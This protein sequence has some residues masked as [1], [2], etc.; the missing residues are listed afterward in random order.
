M[1]YKIKF[2]NPIK[3]YYQIKEEIDAAYFDVMSHGDLIDRRH[4]Y[5]FEQ[6][7]AKFVGT[8]YAVGLNSGY[9]ALH[10]SLRAAGIGLDNEVIIQDAASGFS[11][12]DLH[13][14][15]F[16]NVRIVDAEA[17]DLFGTIEGSAV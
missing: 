15:S 8:K 13:A 5:Q 14:G 6:N 12:R 10:I 4:L 1:N 17:Y 11:T 7:L 9:D 3:N 16:Y 2:V